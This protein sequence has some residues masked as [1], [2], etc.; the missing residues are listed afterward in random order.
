MAATADI[1]G[2]VY[3]LPLVSFLL[4][5]VITYAVLV[6]SKLVEGWFLQVLVPFLIATVFVTAISARDYVLAVIPWFAILVVLLFLVLMFTG[7][8][9]KNA[10]AMQKPIA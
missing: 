9:G 10:E 5:F 3:F 2:I 6:A 1:S 4:V 8:L 7:F